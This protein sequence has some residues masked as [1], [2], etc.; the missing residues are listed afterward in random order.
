MS[1]AEDVLQDAD[2]LSE[3][4]HPSMTLEE[5]ADEVGTYSEKARYWLQ[6]H[7]LY[8][9]NWRWDKPPEFK[10]WQNGYEYVGSSGTDY[11]VVH[12]LV[13]I[14]QGC[15]PEK[16]FSEEW[17]VHHKSRLSWDNRIGNMSLIPHD[18]HPEEH[19]DEFDRDSNGMFI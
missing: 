8:E 16:V 1:Q 14:A 15:E 18:E 7:N 2:K 19:L 9:P 6:K 4:Y 13:A 5:V 17:D 3:I 10:T 12:Q 11:V